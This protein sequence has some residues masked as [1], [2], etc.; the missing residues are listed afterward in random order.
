MR[1]KPAK[2]STDCTLAVA[3]GHFEVP[4]TGARTT[5]AAGIDSEFR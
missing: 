5:I 3:I 4:T 1:V 2:L